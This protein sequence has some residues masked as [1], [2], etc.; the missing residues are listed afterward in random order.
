MTLKDV[1]SALRAIL[2]ESTAVPAAEMR[3]E[4]D[5]I[6]DLGLSSLELVM[7]AAQI[8][9]RLGATLE[10]D[11]VPGWTINEV[12]AA[13]HGKLTKADGTT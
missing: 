9:G 3:G 12:A 10:M 13:I 8:E 4:Q 7:V 11:D 2:S 6:S 5:I 1:D